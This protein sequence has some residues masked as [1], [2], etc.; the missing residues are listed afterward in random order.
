VRWGISIAVALNFCVV[1]PIRAEATATI[2]VIE[3][4]LAIR[5]GEGFVQVAT[6]AEAP[7]GSEV[8]ANPKGAGKVV[9]PDGCEISITPGL[10]YTVQA[11]SPCDRG[12]VVGRVG[13]IVGGLLVA[14]GVIAVVTL[15]GGD[16]GSNGSRSRSRDRD[17]PASP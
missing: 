15:T 2:Q 11:V 13:Y 3:G 14:G 16:D 17:R 7:I 10:L 6:S 9:Y 5:N 1:G 4:T 8:M 12:I